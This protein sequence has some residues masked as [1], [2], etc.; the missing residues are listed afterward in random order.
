MKFN[1]L[2]SLT[3]DLFGKFVSSVKRSLDLSFTISF[4]TVVM[5]GLLL[6]FNPSAA[7]A[8]PITNQI[9]KITQGVNTDKVI[10]KVAGGMKEVS[11]DLRDGR[12]D[13]LI[14]KGA[15]AAKDFTKNAGDAAEDIGDR[16]K[17]LA[18]N[19]GDATRDGVD[20]VK[21]MATKAKN[22]LGDRTGEALDQTKNLSKKTDNAVGEIIDS[23]KD[24]LGQ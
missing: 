8:N 22:T 16:A 15:E 18:K 19:T 4:A 23:V 9:D 2:N 1:L 17:N 24:F 21:D 14:D 20:N 7:I 5:L 11:R 10:D 13:K 12:P 6:Q 3:L